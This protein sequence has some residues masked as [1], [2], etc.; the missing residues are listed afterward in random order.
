LR[1]A[2]SASDSSG[3]SHSIQ[4]NKTAAIPGELRDRG[5]YGVSGEF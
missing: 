2:R 5:F 1:S 4:S 3:P